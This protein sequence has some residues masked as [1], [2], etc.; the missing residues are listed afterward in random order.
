MRGVA[1]AFLAPQ[2]LR[3]HASMEAGKLAAAAFA[4][5]RRAMPLHFQSFAFWPGSAQNLRPV[6][7]AFPFRS[8][9]DANRY[10]ALYPLRDVVQQARGELV[11]RQT[12]HIG[13]GQIRRSIFHRTFMVP[14]NWRYHCVLPFWEGTELAGLLGLHRRAEQGDFHAAELELLRDLHPQVAIAL[15][16]VHRSHQERAKRAVLETI[17]ARIPVPVIVTDWNLSV[18][19]S[20]DAADRFCASATQAATVARRLKIARAVTLPPSLCE[21]C[22][23]LKEAGAPAWDQARAKP[24]ISAVVPDAVAGGNWEA[25]VTLDTMEFA[26]FNQPVFVFQLSRAATDEG[27]GE[28]LVKLATLTAAEQAVASLM[29][30]G[31]SNG[32]MAQRLGKSP[33]TVAKQLQAIFRKLGVNNRT[34]LAA[35]LR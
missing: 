28:R 33:N 23:R 13:L 8:A 35:L 4:L 19:F 26:P 32:E 7:E 17:L 1:E 9:A 27:A 34:R 3:L 30:E 20:N 25:Q 18:L 10:A 29:R 11:I 16:R 15:R 12:D 14:E 31:L 24:S 22:L 2:L 5:M 6:R 21:L